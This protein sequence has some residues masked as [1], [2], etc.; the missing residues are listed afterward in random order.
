MILALNTPL[1]LG[2][3]DNP[4][5]Y[6]IQDLSP[7]QN[8]AE[9]GRMQILIHKTSL[10][11]LEVKLRKM[12]IVLGDAVQLVPEGNDDV[13]AYFIVPSRFPFGFGK[14]RLVRAGYLGDPAKDLLMPALE[15]N[16]PLRVRIVALEAAHLS[17]DGVDSVSISVWGN[18]AD[19]ALPVY[20]T[21]I[22]P[23]NPIND[24]SI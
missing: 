6:G 12:G 10:H 14:P 20:R 19:I 16:A 2:C 24:R 4:I 23:K 3:F 22:Y 5:L 8:R 13:A 15:K 7:Q 17:A 9:R 1:D 11:R 18:P 21:S